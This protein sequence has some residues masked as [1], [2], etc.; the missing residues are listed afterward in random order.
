MSLKTEVGERRRR[1]L[2]RNAYRRGSIPYMGLEVPVSPDHVPVPVLRQI[3]RNDYERPEIGALLKLVRPGDRILELGAGLGIVSSVAV[4][5]ATGVS[6]RSYEANPRM[7]DCVKHLHE[8]NGITA[9]DVQNAIV[10]PDPESDALEFH[11]H[12]YFPQSSLHRDDLTIETVSVPTVDFNDVVREI[13]PTF[14]LCDIEG[15]EA[16]LFEGI[17]LTGIRVIAIELHPDVIGKEALGRIFRTC[18]DAGF[19]P[20]VDCFGEQVVAFERGP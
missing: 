18:L 5:S 3:R 7:V 6:V 13:R 4:R 11:I 19:E 16:R 12:K 20:R 15:G 17:D 14:L 1:Y 8:R 2:D 9:V 10:L